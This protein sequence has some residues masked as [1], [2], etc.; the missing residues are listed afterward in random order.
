MASCSDQGK[1]CT[2]PCSNIWLTRRMRRTICG[3]MSSLLRCK[4]E[5][6]KLNYIVEG[7][8]LKTI[9]M[10]YWA[11]CTGAT[12]PTYRCCTFLC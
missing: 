5:L 1:P 11:I 9:V 4:I 2:P 3:V 7:E 6:L 8:L 12:T 10:F